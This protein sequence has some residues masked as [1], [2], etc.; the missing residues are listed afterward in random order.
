MKILKNS[1]LFYKI[2]AK[3]DTITCY[4]IFKI[5]LFTYKK[6]KTNFN[7]KEVNL[8][9][10]LEFHKKLANEWSGIYRV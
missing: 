10:V 4:Y 2:N 3:T 8:K 9:L 1:I 7:L 6:L 5:N